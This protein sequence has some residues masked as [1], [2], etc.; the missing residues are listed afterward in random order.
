MGGEELLS[1]NIA[2]AAEDMSS[3]GDSVLSYP[4]SISVLMAPGAKI[5]AV[6][7]T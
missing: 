5:P 4:T 2:S 6:S 1:F 7:Y 3:L